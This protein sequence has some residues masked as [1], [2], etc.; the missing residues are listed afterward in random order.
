MGICQV[1][2]FANESSKLSGIRDEF[3]LIINK[4]NWRGG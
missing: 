3:T 4:L 1:Q 2:Q